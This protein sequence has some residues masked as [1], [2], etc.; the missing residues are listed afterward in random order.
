MPPVFGPASP[1]PIRLKSCAAP[2]GRIRR[3]SQSANSETSLPSSSSSITTPPP[4]PSTAGSAASSSCWVWQT[5]TPLPDASPSALIT[6]GGRAIEASRQS[7]RPQRAAHPSRSSSSPRCGRRRRSGR[8]R[9]RHFVAGRPRP[10]SRAAPP[11]RS[12]RGPCRAT[13]RARATRRRP[14]RAPD[15]TVRGPRSPDSRARRAARSAPSLCERRHASACSRAP[16]PTSRTFTR[17]VYFR[18]LTAA[19]ARHAVGR[20]PGIDEHG[21]NR[22]GG[23]RIARRR[24]RPRRSPRR[25]IWSRG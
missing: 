4:S 8:R 23:D 22:V 14:R 21:E 2:S 16:D 19:R 10:P 18:R 13:G 5:K 24:S 12:R 17:G 25:M 9:Q 20:A 6:Q 11:A 1:S 7:V 15:G 3:P